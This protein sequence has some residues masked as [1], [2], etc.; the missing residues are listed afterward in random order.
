MKVLK[1]LFVFLFVN[2]R[3][4]LGKLNLGFF[5]LVLMSGIRVCG[6]GF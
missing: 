5:I 3:I 6:K 1:N 4:G 2:I